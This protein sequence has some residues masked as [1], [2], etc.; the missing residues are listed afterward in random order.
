MSEKNPLDS[1]WIDFDS[2]D[3]T[4]DN[5]NINLDKLRDS[6]HSNDSDDSIFIPELEENRKASSKRSDETDSVSAEKEPGS[7]SKKGFSFLP[8]LAILAAIILLAFAGYKGYKLLS[9]PTAKPA[10]RTVMNNV[11]IAGVNVGGLYRTQAID[12]VTAGLAQTLYANAMQVELPDISISIDPEEAGLYLDVAAAVDAAMEYGRSGPDAQ[13]QVLAAQ[14]GDIFRLNILPYLRVNE[15]YLRTVLSEAADSVIGSFQPSSYFL[16]GSA[17]ILDSPQFD[18][19][20]PCQTLVLRK[21]VP[22]EG[23]DPEALYN[24]V[25]AAYNDGLT[26]VSVSDADV[27][28]IPE[29]LDLDLIHRIL[30]VSPTEAVLD[31]KTLTIIPGTYGYTFNLDAARAAL[32]GADYGTEVTVPMEY[33]APGIRS[34]GV[35]CTDELASTTLVCETAK[36]PMLHTAADVVSQVII[37]AGKS[38]NYQIPSAMRKEVADCQKEPVEDDGFCMVATALYRSAMEAGLQTKA[39]GHHQYF[40]DYCEKGMDVR[41]HT[42]QSMT[43]RNNSQSPVMIL[44]EIDSSSFTVRIMGTETRTYSNVLTS[45]LDKEIDFKVTERNEGSASNHTNG[46]V[47]QEGINDSVYVVHLKTIDSQTGA[48]LTDEVIETIKYPGRPQIIAHITR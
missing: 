34:D 23:V 35:Y 19:S 18:P 8:P 45:Q 31:S 24:D 2:Q 16:D 37:P 5:V 38:F 48:V 21:G 43:I 1:N 12:A 46:Q 11:Y 17:P 36:Y 33:I 32:D 4:P 14:G 22:G 40:P 20:T 27:P 42:S 29:A 44:V 3:S 7:Q 26:S 15:D 13:A 9:T 47:L 39:P 28:R 30:A 6:I 41:I 25:L 10:E